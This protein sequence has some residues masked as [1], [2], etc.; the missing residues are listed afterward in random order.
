MA[1]GYPTLK[2]NPDAFRYCTK[3]RFCYF[4][5]S[6]GWIA[7]WIFY[8]YFSLNGWTRNVSLAV[9]VG[10]IYVAVHVLSRCLRHKYNNYAVLVANDTPQRAGGEMHL[11]IFNSPNRLFIRCVRC[12][13]SI[14][15]LLCPCLTFRL[16]F[17]GYKLDRIPGPPLEEECVGSFKRVSILPV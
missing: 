12:I 14:E 3:E 9:Y 15:R 10:N 8:F 13:H 16:F 6:F 1:S 11:N 5:G 17:Y 7:F 4:V 2:I